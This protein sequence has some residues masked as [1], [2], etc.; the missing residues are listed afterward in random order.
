MNADFLIIHIIYLT[1]RLDLKKIW[2]TADDN[3][4]ANL[5]K[6]QMM[7]LIAGGLPPPVAALKIVD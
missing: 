4:R 7:I 6:T 3:Q 2:V 5:R 1:V